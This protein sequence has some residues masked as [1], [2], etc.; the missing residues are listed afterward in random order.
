MPDINIGA[1]SEVIN[2]KMDRDLNNRSDDSGL[3]KLV[4][5]YTNGSSWYK[6]FDEIQSDGTVKKWC[7]QGG[8]AT[9][10]T[11][12]YTFLKPYLNSPF[13]YFQCNSTNTGTATNQGAWMINSIPTTTGFT[14]MNAF[15]SSCHLAGYWRAEGYIS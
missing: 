10:G 7:E 9:L 2:D 11:F 5:S 3:R 12:S 4:E 8:Q 13:V 1:L 15:T 14:I 6:V